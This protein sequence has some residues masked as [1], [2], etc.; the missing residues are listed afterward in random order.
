VKPKDNATPEFNN[1]LSIK[2]NFSNKLSKQVSV[3]SVPSGLFFGEELLLKQKKR[4][5]TAKSTSNLHCYII[6]NEVIQFI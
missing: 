5:C 3:G 4:L 6:R 2:C 1:D